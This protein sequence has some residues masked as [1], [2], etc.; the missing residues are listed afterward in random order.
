MMKTFGGTL[1]LMMALAMCATVLG[2]SASQN[3]FRKAN[4][5]Y[6][7]KDRKNGISEKYGS[8]SKA[9]RVLQ[10]EY[11]TISLHEYNRG[12][13]LVM[14]N[15]FGF[16]SNTN[17]TSSL[18]LYADGNMTANTPSRMINYP[19]IEWGYN[20]EYI[21]AKLPEGTNLNNEYLFV[22][23]TS[24]SVTY[25]SESPVYLYADSGYS[26]ML[27]VSLALSVIFMFMSCCCWCS[28][29]KQFYHLVRIA[30]L[31][32]MINMISSRPHPSGSFALLDN[33]RHNILNIMPNPVMI[34][35]F[36]G[37][38]CQPSIEFYGQGWSCHAYNSLRN[39]VLGFI[40][41]VVLNFFI[42]VNKFHDREFFARLRKTMD[43]EIFMLAIM[44]DVFLAIYVNA[45]AGL[46]NSVLSIG[47]LFSILLTFWYGYIFTS[48][49]GNYYSHNNQK[50]VDFLQFFV[51]SR[52]SL[53]TK[54]TSIG[55]KILAVT[56]DNIKILVVTTMIG[57]FYNAPKTQM[58]L[59]FVIF[60]LNAL[61]LFAVRPYLNI[62]QNIFFGL[63]DICFCI[64]VIL[65]FANHQQFYNTVMETKEGPY[66]SGMIA[67]VIFI[68]ILNLI[69]FI[70]PVLKGTDAVGVAHRKTTEIS[71]D[72]DGL[73]MHSKSI[74]H[75]DKR[76][77]EKSELET[78]K[79]SDLKNQ[80][81]KESVEKQ[82]NPERDIH[83][84]E[85][86]K[87]NHKIIL[88]GDSLHKRDET[89][90]MKPRESE[91]PGG[92]IQTRKIQ[93]KGNRPSGPDGVRPGDEHLNRERD[94]VERGGN[95]NIIH[96]ENQIGENTHIKPKKNNLITGSPDKTEDSKVASHDRLNMDAPRQDMQSSFVRSGELP[97][98]KSGKVPVRR[99]FKPADVQ[100]QDYKGM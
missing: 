3:K 11:M 16:T 62:W 54:D 10:T 66:D 100:Q 36:K 28:G 91:H 22:Q 43:I 67:M 81:V 88:G 20:M 64:L 48:Y 59:I 83:T 63:S 95:I 85:G 21:V 29:I 77:S 9:S 92:P 47:F 94:Q 57:L 46:T 15:I 18:K 52:N 24:S 87:R 65:I 32:H 74:L 17:L 75:N 26:G 35:E 96:E 82:R 55:L 60:F 44:P 37:N 51:F 30:Q 71:Q 14:K 5:A 38:E 72:D 56:F 76:V 79:P 12:R 4:P 25:R 89:V 19:V 7:L 2:G 70:V 33:F 93:I 45:V 42:S 69:V 49:I 50:T 80:I 8:V 78:E 61:F 99:N 40:I 73:N 31:L 84:A 1:I 58:V 53:S 34:D 39:Y 41:Y 27:S 98:V 86:N 23:R 13:T 97:P 6:S 68:F 90:P